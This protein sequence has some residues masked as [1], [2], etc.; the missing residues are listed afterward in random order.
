VIALRALVKKELA[1]LFGSPVAWLTLA[2]TGVVTALVF[3]ERLR[4]YNQT[5]FVWATST[6]GGFDAD[7]IPDYVNLR[8]LVFLPMMQ[9]LGVM[10]IGLVPL[11]TMRS[12]AEE[13]ARGTDELLLS[14]QLSPTQITAAKYL[15]TFAFVGLMLAVSF[16]Y[17]ATSILRS[18]L[19]LRHLVAVYGGLLVLGLGIAA[20]GLA[21]SAYTASQ[22]VAAISAY[23]AAFVLYDFAWAEPFLR[24]RPGLASVLD[25]ISLQP[26]YLGFAEGL[27]EV[28]N[29][30]YFAA[31]ALVAAFLARTSFDLERVR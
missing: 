9:Q 19:G 26:R 6:M 25:A 15:A 1:V 14:T 3:F 18:G 30:V 10:L 17:P 4:V 12:F 22:L 27:V 29:L 28:A 20:I 16:V 7:T 23:A 13:R 2:M 21:C 8:E 24:D 11:V 31:L 5:V